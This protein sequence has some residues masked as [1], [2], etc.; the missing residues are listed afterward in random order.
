[1]LTDKEAKSRSESPRL[2]TTGIKHIAGLARI[3]I[4][5]KEG[6]DLKKD[7]SSILEYIDK[8]NEVDTE[9]VEPLYQTTGLVDSFR[10]DE[11][12]GEFKMDDNLNEKLI[13]QAPNQQDRFIKVRS[14]FENKK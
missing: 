5:E 13:G 7:L 6:K 9:K 11:P 10:S 4:S 2:S 8:L 12:K 14:V 1:M 3:K